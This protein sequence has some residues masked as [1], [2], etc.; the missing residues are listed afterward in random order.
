MD[1]SPFGINL[2]IEG[3]EIYEVDGDRLRVRAGE[4]LMISAGLPVRVILEGRSLNRAICV[5]LPP[6]LATSLAARAI[7]TVQWPGAVVMSAA[8]SGMGKELL[9]HRPSSFDEVA[10]R[11]LI[12]SITRQLPH[13]ARTLRDR[14]QHLPSVKVATRR[15]LLQRLERSYAH[16]CL[17][18]GELASVEEMAGMAGMSVPHFA[19]AFRNV[20]GLPPSRLQQRLRMEAAA[21]AIS[22]NLITPL[23]AVERFGFADQ[24]SFTRAFRRHV[25]TSPGKLKSSQASK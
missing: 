24:A 5:C 15:S 17:E 1:A 7:S 23:E 6:A 20:Y 21:S 19:R 11:R 16:F 25:G 12:S 22:N 2:V 14:I 9:Q 13:F 10:A 3:E 8:T 4:M 18:E